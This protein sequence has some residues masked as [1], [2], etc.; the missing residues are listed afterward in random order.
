MKA[1]PARAILSLHLAVF[2]FGSAGVVGKASGLAALVLVFGR[3]LF[4]FVTLTPCL[5]WRGQ[6]G[7]RDIR[8][9]WWS[10][11]G[12]GVLL[13]LHWLAFFAAVNAADVAYG[14]MG[15]ASYPLFVAGLEP[16][17]FKE[18]GH[19][20]DWLAALAVL[21]GMWLM[22]GSAGWGGGALA[23]LLLG[24]LSGLSFAVLTLLYRWQG[25]HIPPFKLAW[26][27]NG[28]ACLALAPFAPWP[29]ILSA[30]SWLYLLVLGVIFTALSHGLFM[31][32]LQTVS[33]RL[34]S[35]TAALEPVYGML[36]AF[37]WLREQPSG[38]ALLGCAVILAATT[39]VTLSHATGKEGG[40]SH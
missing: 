38:R 8:A 24:V 35:L 31:L 40:Q 14:L 15:F 5:A 18:P 30:Q 25:G 23:G 17:V 33:A 11:A 10:I 36:L 19:R 20:R 6:L 7:H 12:C 9:W 28:V 29:L 22:A 21:L 39:A 32:S 34:A 4:A 26:L 3:C 37:L 27:Q 13:A 1:A 16:L 2:L